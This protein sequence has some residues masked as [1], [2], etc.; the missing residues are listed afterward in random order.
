MSQSHARSL[1]G[2]APISAWLQTPFLVY[3]SQ[4]DLTVST[5]PPFDGVLIGPSLWAWRQ[6]RTTCLLA[7]SR[8]IAEKEVDSTCL[9]LTFCAASAIV[10]LR[11]V[12]TA[13]RYSRRPRRS[14][15]GLCCQL[16][17]LGPPLMRN[18]AAG[19]AVSASAAFLGLRRPGIL[20]TAR[21]D[22]CGPVLHDLA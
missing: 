14:C 21:I 17:L 4:S 9:P 8:T 19:F 16:S 12:R 18:L 11:Q 3:C 20:G 1:W 6:V 2:L 15:S 22:G 7:K 5:H 10:S 13:P